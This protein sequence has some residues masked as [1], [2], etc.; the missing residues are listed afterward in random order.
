[1]IDK[2]RAVQDLASTIEDKRLLVIKCEEL[3]KV[4]GDRDEDS[5]S[6]VRIDELE[7][8]LKDCHIQ[9]RNEREGACKRV[10]ELISVKRKLEQDLSLSLRNTA[11]IRNS[12][13]IKVQ[14]AVAHLKKFR[15]HKNEI[16]IQKAYHALIG[17][18]SELLI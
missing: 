14:F 2:L 16:Y 15:E 3:T 1:M 5:E 7:S 13:D 17:M 12:F 18:G 4:I 11:T 9:L 10:N 8:V 6:T